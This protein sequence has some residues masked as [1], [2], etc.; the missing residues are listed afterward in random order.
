MRAVYEH[1]SGMYKYKI[2]LS[3][4]ILLFIYLCF[5]GKR[6]CAN[7]PLSAIFAYQSRS[8]RKNNFSMP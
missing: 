4:Y 5:W 1:F 7:H 3:I 2:Y 8:A 6:A